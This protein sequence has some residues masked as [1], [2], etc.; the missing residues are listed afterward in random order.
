[1]I[2]IFLIFALC[3]ILLSPYIVSVCKRRRMLSHLTSVA[4]DSG[5]RVHR[6]HRLVSLSRNRAPY[7]DLLLESKERAYAVKLWSATNMHA[8]LIIGE[9][10]TFCER[11]MLPPTLDTD[12]AQSRAHTTKRRSVP[13]TRKNFKIKEGKP[14]ECFMLCYPQNKAVLIE[15]RGGRRTLQSGERIFDKILCTPKYLLELISNNNQLEK[16]K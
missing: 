3:L 13:R 15:G 11:A 16:I 14:L 8:S 9:D 6:L 12:S 1:M 5:F 4:K 2:F 10:G 7:Y